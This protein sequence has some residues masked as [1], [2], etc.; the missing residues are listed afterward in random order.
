MDLKKSAYLEPSEPDFQL[1]PR[2]ESCKLTRWQ[3]KYRHER[4]LDCLDKLN[5]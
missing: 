3:Q 1:Q 5:F 2:S 4:S